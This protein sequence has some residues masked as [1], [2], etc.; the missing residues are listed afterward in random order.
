MTERDCFGVVVRSIGLLVIIVT[1][2]Y[3]GSGLYVVLAPTA[4]H[5][6]TAT[7]YFT[8]AVG[9][10]LFGLYLLRGAKHLVNFAYPS[11]QQAP[12]NQ[13]KSMDLAE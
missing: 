4:A 11:E 8:F 13:T 5:K 2:A 9:Y 1:I 3:V 12:A 10:G 6:A 7:S